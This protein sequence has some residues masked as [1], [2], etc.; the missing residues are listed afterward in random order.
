[1]N[2]RDVSAWP[3]QEAAN[4][5]VRAFVSG[6]DTSLDTSNDTAGLER[7]TPCPVCS[8]QNDLIPPPT[9]IPE[10]LPKISGYDIVRELGKGGMGVVYLARQLQADRLVAVKMIRD[11]ALAGPEDVAR[12]RV[13]AQAAAGITHPNIVR[14]YEVGETEG[15]P[16]FVQ[17]YVEG[18]RL[19]RLLAATPQAPRAAAQIVETLA[20]AMQSAH[21]QHVIHRDL[22]AGQRHDG[23]RSLA[24]SAPECSCR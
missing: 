4:M 13:E 24:A 9:S 10:I 5:A 15:R 20:R 6:K 7:L 17:E 16:F 12:F 3:L 8:S 22:E 1:M 2:Q 23:W 19:D 14:V 18:D 11:S 21:D